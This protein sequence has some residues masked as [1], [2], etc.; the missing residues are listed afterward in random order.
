VKVLAYATRDDLEEAAELRRR[1][2]QIHMLAVCV[3]KTQ[4]GLSATKKRALIE[5]L[6]R[7]LQGD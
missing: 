3:I 4:R 1:L 2:Q 7:E 6:D 5:A